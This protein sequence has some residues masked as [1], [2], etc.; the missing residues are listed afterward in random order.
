MGI[1]ANTG[2]WLLLPALFLFALMTSCGDHGAELLKQMERLK[3]DLAELKSA[4][5]NSSVVMD[6]LAN[7][8]LLLQDQVES[9][10]LMLQRN[11]MPEPILP[12]VKLRP[13]R[14]AERAEQDFSVDSAPEVSFQELSEN[15]LLVNMSGSQ[16]PVVEE[17]P[18]AERK[19]RTFDSRPLEI[20]KHAYSLLMEKRHAEAVMEFERFLEQY[21]NH[22][23]SDNS[24]YWLGEAYY[25]TQEFSRALDYFDRVIT[26]Y[27]G[28]N[29]VPD[30][31][32]KSGLCY[33]NIGDQSSASE[34]KKVLL[35]SYPATPAAKKARE[36]L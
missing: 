30:A 10:Q 1:R 11:P 33:K 19:N 15:G 31:L 5:A 27:P 12:V 3:R 13:G 22:D 6:D 34:M 9:N 28:G 21:P 20:Y 17:R 32:L 35:K 8:I 24:L 36:L 29:K 25:D 23:Y 7:R 14:R 18:R 4:G 16:D 2:R 26:L